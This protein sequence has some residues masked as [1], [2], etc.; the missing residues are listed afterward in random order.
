MNAPLST[1]A[2]NAAEHARLVAVESASIIQS[3]IMINP[4]TLKVT[5]QATGFNYKL[6]I[7][8]ADV[9]EPIEL[10]YWPY[11]VVEVKTGPGWP[12]GGGIGPVIPPSN[13]FYC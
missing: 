2:F 12:K 5:A 9:F 8:P 3:S 13:V 6:E 11:H 10:E 1:T 7:I 4:S